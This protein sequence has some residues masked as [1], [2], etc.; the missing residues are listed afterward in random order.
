VSGILEGVLNFASAHYGSVITYSCGNPD[1]N[2]AITFSSKSKR[3]LVCS[4][5]GEEIDW[6]GIATKMIK[7]CPECNQQFGIDERYCPY[8][9]PKV[10]LIEKEIPL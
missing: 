9:L 7:I 4:K 6:V 1:C 3:P 10:A 2:A 5:C 8:H